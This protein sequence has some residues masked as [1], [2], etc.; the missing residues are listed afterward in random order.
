MKEGYCFVNLHT[1]EDAMRAKQI[2]HGQD[3]NGNFVM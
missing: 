1:I 3:L 2:M